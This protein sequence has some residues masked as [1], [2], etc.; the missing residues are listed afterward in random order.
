M[1]VKCHRSCL[2]G[3]NGVRCCSTH[4]FLPVFDLAV[5]LSHGGFYL[6]DAEPHAEGLFLQGMLLLLQDLYLLQH[7]LVLLLHLRK[8][9]LENKKK[10]ILVRKARTGPETIIPTYKNL[11][12]VLACWTSNYHFMR[13]KV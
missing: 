10:K 9:C 1:T 11:E 7:P 13:Y 5:V 4:L 6:L 12:K 3:Q 8:C 2:K